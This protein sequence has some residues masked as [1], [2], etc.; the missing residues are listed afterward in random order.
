[1]KQDAEK[2]QIKISSM[3]VSKKLKEIIDKKKDVFYPENKSFDFTAPDFSLNTTTN[4][5]TP[6]R[7]LSPMPKP[8]KN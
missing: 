3:L 6:T 2:K 7:K 1:M 5:S 4:F 8:I